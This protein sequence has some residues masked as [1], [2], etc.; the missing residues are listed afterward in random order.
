MNN[1]INKELLDFTNN[2]CKVEDASV[3]VALDTSDGI[4]WMRN[5]LQAH[6]VPTTGEEHINDAGI[7]FFPVECPNNSNH[8]NAAIMVMPNDTISYKCFHDSC[9]EFKWRDF[10]LTYEPAAYSQRVA[11]LPQSLPAT[12]DN[13]EDESS[14]GA[15]AIP[16]PTDLNDAAFYGLAGEV[17][18]GFDPYTEADKPATL[19]SFLVAFG[20]I[21]NRS[22][23]FIVSGT[24]HYTNFF[25]GLVGRTAGGR[26]GTSW[27]LVRAL[28]EAVEQTWAI[29]RTA[30][31][32]SS[33][34][35]LVFQVRDPVYG[36]N[37]KGEEFTKDEGEPDKRL[38]IIESEL[39]RALQVMKREGNTLS[40]VLREAWDGPAILRSLTKNDNTRA[41]LPHI[42]I[43]GHITREELRRDLEANS[44]TNG[45]VNRFLWV[46]VRRSKLLPEGNEEYTTIIKNLAERL[47]FVMTWAAAKPQLIT[48]SDAARVEWH[49]VYP[50]LSREKPGILGFVTA[51]AE[52]Q[53]RRLAVLYA[54]LDCSEKIEL[55]HLQGA[56]AVFAYC[57]QSAEYIFGSE[58][59]VNDPNEIKII[60]YLR[61]HG[62]CSQTTITNKVFKKRNTMKM[63]DALESLSAR[64]VVG[65]RKIK[66]ENAVKTTQ[67]WYLTNSVN[68]NPTPQP[69][70][71]DNTEGRNS[72]NSVEISTG[73][74]QTQTDMK[75][76]E[77]FTKPPGVDGP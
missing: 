20:N 62:D 25:V 61:N 40:A 51:R 36:L 57:E 44:Y 64:G 74:L 45:L 27:G 24:P 50:I 33:G 3:P 15:N 67:M 19:I 37:R 8:K 28:F 35:G 65:C 77:M 38:L 5:W 63:R 70:L 9:S 54:V 11:T 55:S 22:A 42:S 72:A 4:G 60:E 30:N 48:L 75:L 73:T 52:A 1:T 17:A 23:F 12:S 69:V 29:N 71:N 31:G 43:I 46:C 58:A 6:N 2:G 59:I 14:E 13:T 32:L 68:S 7:T 26:K 47:L 41:S 34:E 66:T 16:W 56:L 53:V 39:A 21:I 76:F 10:R 18:N 49:R